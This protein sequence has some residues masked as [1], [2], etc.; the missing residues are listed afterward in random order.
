MQG[1]RN[2]GVDVQTI[3][4]DSFRQS[5]WW[6]RCLS[7]VSLASDGRKLLNHTDCQ[8]LQ[9]NHF[10]SA[11]LLP[12]C[13]FVF[14]NVHLCPRRSH[15]S[16]RTHPPTSRQSGP[17]LT[18]GPVCCNLLL[19]PVQ[20]QWQPCLLFLSPVQR[21]VVNSL[22]QIDDELHCLNVLLG[23]RDQTVAQS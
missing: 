11:M 21:R 6:F 15:K 4:K 18:D 12:S 13:A 16:P 22:Q 5:R 3:W 23:H 2:H 19:T 10:D 14:R 20:S 9:Q 8:N 7:K 17:S 1:R